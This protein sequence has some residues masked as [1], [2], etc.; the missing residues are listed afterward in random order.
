MRAGGP[1]VKGI[2]LSSHT[3]G[4]K[5]VKE[6]FHS[7]TKKK[8]ASDKKISLTKENARLFLLFSVVSQFSSG[9]NS[10]ENSSLG[11]I[12]STGPGGVR[13]VRRG[14][15][16]S[17]TSALS[18]RDAAEGWR[19]LRKE[20][21]KKVFEKNGCSCPFYRPEIFSSNF[22]KFRGVR[23]V[24]GGRRRA[25]RALTYEFLVHVQRHVGI[26]VLLV[27]VLAKVQLVSLL[28]ICWSQSTRLAYFY[29]QRAREHVG[30]ECRGTSECVIGMEIARLFLCKKRKLN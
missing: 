24:N 21:R 16:S 19:P 7:R 30:G 22:E 28:I 9:E 18:M 17:A 15:F 6:S 26:Q 10:N 20:R 14:D 12:I 29:P 3:R 1:A 25:G 4:E 11:E 2:A 8:S 27:V 23:A 5:N 13:R